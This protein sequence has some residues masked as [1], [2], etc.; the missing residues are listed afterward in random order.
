MVNNAAFALCSSKL[1]QKL[2]DVAFCVITLYKAFLVDDF[3]VA[4]LQVSAFVSIDR[5]DWPRPT[6]TPDMAMSLQS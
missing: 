2:V 3:A 6:C 1:Q 4:K 5:F